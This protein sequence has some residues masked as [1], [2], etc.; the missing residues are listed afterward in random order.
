MILIQILI[1]III[2]LYVLLMILDVD[3]KFLRGYKGTIK[4]I[5]NKANVIILY[6]YNHDSL[7]RDSNSAMYDFTIIS[8]YKKI[9]NLWHIWHYSVDESVFINNKVL[10][11]ILLTA[12]QYNEIIRTDLDDKRNIKDK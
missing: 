5:V 4:N 6:T 1:L 2:M 10:T 9:N 11:E 12:V 7:Y 8:K 3:I